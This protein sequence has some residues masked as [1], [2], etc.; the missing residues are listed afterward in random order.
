MKTLTSLIVV[1]A[2]VWIG[3]YSYQN[4]ASPE[5][6]STVSVEGT[7]VSFRELARG[8]RSEVSERT[9]YLITSTD[10]LRALWRII[11]APG[12]TPTIDFTKSDVVAVF[13]G[14]QPTVG[15]EIQVAAVADAQ[16]RM[17]VV[18]VT[19]PGASCLVGEAVT[20]P[21]QVIELPKTTLPLGH[22]DEQRVNSCLQ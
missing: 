9:N 2:L 15:Y 13:T 10:Q 19:R 14:D 3:I 22:K 16:S 17:V 20:N 6:S 7:P 12:Q 5:K 4:Y 8:S 21:Y 11:D 18:A 1:A